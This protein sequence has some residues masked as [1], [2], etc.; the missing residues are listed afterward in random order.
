MLWALHYLQNVPTGQKCSFPAALG[1]ALGSAS[2][3]EAKRSRSLYLRG[4]LL[5]T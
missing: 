2:A 1:F 3:E 4:D 5:L